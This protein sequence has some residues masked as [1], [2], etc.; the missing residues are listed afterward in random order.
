M[1]DHSFWGREWLSIADDQTAFAMDRVAGK[2]QDRKLGIPK[3]GSL[4]PLTGFILH[5]AA[6]IVSHSAKLS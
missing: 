1:E 3:L 6:L 2:V 4:M 5:T